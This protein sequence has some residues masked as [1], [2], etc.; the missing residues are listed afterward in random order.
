VVWFMPTPPHSH[1][2]PMCSRQSRSTSRALPTP[3]TVA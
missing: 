2:K 3:S 1:S